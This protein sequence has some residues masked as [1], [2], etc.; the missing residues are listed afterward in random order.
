MADHAGPSSSFSSIENQEFD[1]IIIGG[2]TAGLVVANRLTEDANTRVL[3][4]EAGGDKKNDP[5]VYTPGLMSLL[6]GDPE[7][8]WDYLTPP[9]PGLKGRQLGHS[10]GKML[11]GSSGINFAALFYPAKVD[12]DTWAS[13]GNP[14]WESGSALPYLR[15][16][17]TYHAPTAA[18]TD[19]IKLD[20]LDHSIQGTDGPVQASFGDSFSPG[21]QAW[22]DTFNAL[23]YK[24]NNDPI[25]GQAIGP[26]TNNHTV[27]PDT[28]ER[29]YSRVAYYDDETAKR[30]NL[31]VLTEALV[32][33]ILL[34]GSDG[35][36]TA[37]GVQ[38]RT[39][40]GEHHTITA[41]DEVILSAGSI[42]SPQILEL[43]GIGERQRLESLGIPVVIDNPNVGENL[44]DHPSS[45]ISYEL[46]DGIMSAD[47]LIN[48]EISKQ[49]V[50]LYESSRAGPLGGTW[51][52][53]AYMPFVDA[54]GP[55]NDEKIRELID[56][57]ID[58]KNLSPRLKLQYKLL[59]EILRNPKESSGE[60][61][62]LP[63]QINMRQVLSLSDIMNKKDTPGQFITLTVMLNRPFSRGHVHITSADPAVKPIF[64]PKLLSHPLDAEILG[65][66]TQFIEKIASTEPLAS[67]IKKNGLRIP[68][69]RTAHTLEDAK[70]MVADRVFTPYH[71][72]GTCSMMPRETGGVVNERL[73]VHG[74]RNLRVVDASIFPLEPLGNIQSVVYLVA[75]KASDIIKE[76]RKQ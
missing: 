23:G 41:K 29:S 1:I 28:R 70:D 36:V 27:H 76:D 50:E 69:G 44:Q 52:S 65:R 68:S 9:Q 53:G 11:G 57:H 25:T 45:H 75:E 73:V 46:A 66:H 10:K 7:V 18:T 30:P 48:P 5:R 8:D 59:S 49:L 71:P 6:Y 58:E 21:N 35:F 40:D 55:V 60:Y 74:T 43:S 37:T 32:E 24:I 2:G 67:L 20:Y 4:I 19:V 15:K 61:L 63:F 14:G 12:M 54:D 34:A 17:H 3:V 13:L 56:A 38:I 42:N 64:D 47:A 26:F 72:S 62:Y 16:F 33:K 39:K 31:H 51:L 22:M